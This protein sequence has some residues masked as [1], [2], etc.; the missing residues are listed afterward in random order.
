MPHTIFHLWCFRNAFEKYFQVFP[1]ITIDNKNWMHNQ[2]LSIANEMYVQS[3]FKWTK[4]INK[5]KNFNETGWMNV[6][7]KNKIRFNQ[8][9]ITLTF[10]FDSIHLVKLNRRLATITN[11]I[12]FQ[13][14]PNVESVLARSID[15]PR[16]LCWMLCD[17]AR[18]N[19]TH[20]S[21]WYKWMRPSPVLPVVYTIFPMSSAKLSIRANMSDHA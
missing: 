12:H 10:S 5:S 18:W 3:H 1:L 6:H 15:L 13:L 21:D 19:R 9:G 4:K 20:N 11:Q 8:M 16:G 7:Q 17:A 2:V 14:F